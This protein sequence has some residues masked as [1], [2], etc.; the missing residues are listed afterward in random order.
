MGVHTN[1][2]EDDDLHDL[3]DSAVSAA[4]DSDQSSVASWLSM[5]SDFHLYVNFNIEER[6]ARQQKQQ[7]LSELWSSCLFLENLRG[8]RAVPDEVVW[9]ISSCLTS[10]LSPERV[11]E[12]MLRWRQPRSGV[13]YG[14]YFRRFLRHL[15]RSGFERAEPVLLSD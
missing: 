11:R 14:H 9:L 15:A 1:N 7:A 2:V 3:E 12:R 8:D 6:R 10:D 4:S 13:A 5:F